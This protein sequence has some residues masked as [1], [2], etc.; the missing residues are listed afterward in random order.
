MKRN[1]NPFEV[2]MP[3]E[4]LPALTKVT[5]QQNQVNLTLSFN[6]PVHWQH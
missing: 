5:L 4:S 2:Q 1:K 6:K 3:L